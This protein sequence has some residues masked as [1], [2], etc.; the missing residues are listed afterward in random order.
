MLIGER[1]RAGSRPPRSLEQYQEFVEACS[2]QE[3]VLSPTVGDVSKLWW[4]LTW[5][6]GRPVA[7]LEQGPRVALRADGSVHVSGAEEPVGAGVGVADGDSPEHDV[8]D[9][10]DDDDD[11]FPEPAPRA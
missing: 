2:A 8:F 9:E 3:H 10:D 4:T 5:L 11:L 6:E 1:W 7:E